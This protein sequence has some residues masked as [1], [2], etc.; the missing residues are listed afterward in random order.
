M[1]KS[2]VEQ[3][4]GIPDSKEKAEK[5]LRSGQMPTRQVHF[6]RKHLKPSEKE[7]PPRKKTDTGQDD[8]F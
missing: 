3:D 7:K 4:V 8:L 2:S 1:R 5:R 6:F